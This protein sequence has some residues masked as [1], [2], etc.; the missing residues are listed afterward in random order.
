[1]NQPDPSVPLHDALLAAL[2]QQTDRLATAATDAARAATAA[3]T[4]LRE[5]YHFSRRLKVTLALGLVMLLLQLVS[6]GV[7]IF[8]AAQ[9]HS[10]AATINDCT[11]PQGECAQRGQ[12]QTG[13]AI[14]QIVARSIAGFIVVSECSRHTT[15][16]Q[17]LESCVQQRLPR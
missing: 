12:Q 5:S 11:S 13:V 9:N 15:T 6:G 4:E 2:N 8:F 10:L 1:M 14:G 7:L 16:D 3:A 17:E